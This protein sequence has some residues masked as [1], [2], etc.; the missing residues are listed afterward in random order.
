MPSERQTGPAIAPDD[1]VV[2][3]RTLLGTCG[4]EPW[5]VKVAVAHVVINRVRR[6]GW[7]GASVTEVCR[8]PWQFTCWNEA[9][10]RRRIEAASCETP[11]LRECLAVAAAA[12]GGLE[13]DRTGGACHLRP[14][15]QPLDQAD[16][17]PPSASIG[18]FSFYLEPDDTHDFVNG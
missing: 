16:Q 8:A 17:R 6:G 3:A 10:E 5:P 12:L 13:P 11:A 15:G 18:P 9:A 1:L 14:R 7:W 2:L 4:R